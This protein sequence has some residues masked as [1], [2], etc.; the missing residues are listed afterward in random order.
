MEDPII[1]DHAKLALNSSCHDLNFWIFWLQ[2]WYRLLF[3]VAFCC[4][5]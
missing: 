5:L 1:L 2:C 3:Q 4:T